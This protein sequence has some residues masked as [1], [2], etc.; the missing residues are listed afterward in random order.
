MAGPG[1]WDKPNLLFFL[2]YFNLQDYFKSFSTTSHQFLKRSI[3][4]SLGLGKCRPNP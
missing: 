4:C 2:D 3:Q 1:I